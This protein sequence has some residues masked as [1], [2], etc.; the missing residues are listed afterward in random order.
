[1]AVDPV[2]LLV[3][4]VLGAGGAALL[5]RQ[6]EHARVPDGLAD[7]LGWGFLVDEGV[8]ALKDGGLLAAFRYRGPDLGS[9]TG[10]ELAALTEQL[11]D[12]LLP[13]GD[14]WMFHVDAIREP[15]PPYAASRFPD[16]VTAWIDAERRQAYDVVSGVGDRGHATPDERSR[17]ADRRAG[18]LRPGI[19]RTGERRT[20]AARPQFVSTYTLTATF[21][22]PKELYTRAG[23]LFVQPGDRPP[24]GGIEHAGSAIAPG[25]PASAAGA[26][27]SGAWE[28]MLAGYT[29]ALRTLEDRIGAR[30]HVERL[31]SDAL[32]THLHRTLTGLAH[33]VEA[34]PAGA[35]LD[36]VLASQ[37]L[38][39]GFAPRVGDQHLR[40][41]AITGYPATATAGRLDVLN[42]LPFAYRWSSRF[43]PLSQHAA[44]KLLKRHQQQWFMGRKGLGSFLRDIASTSAP[45]DWQ[46]QQ[47]ETLFVDQHASA[48]ARD[49]ADAMAENAS[50]AV[51]F[52]L[53]SQVVVTWD[54]DPDVAEA[55]ARAV[56]RTL[57]DAGVTARVETVNALD[58]FLGTLPGHGYANLRRQV[59]STPNAAALWPVTS[60]W[61]GQGEHPS[62]F[63]P[64]ASP[65]LM[66]VATDGSTPFRLNLHVSDLGHTL[67][68]G[69]PGAGKSTFVGLTIAQWQRY[70]ASAG[71]RTFVFDVGYSHWLLAK[72][73]GGAH[74]DIAAPGTTTPGAEDN[75]GGGPPLAF[76]PLADVE[77][78]EER[79]WAASW[80]EM[81][82]E[83]QGVAMTPT[84]RLALDRALV[85]L[86][87]QPRPYRTLTELAVQCQDPDVVAAL[88]PY[89]VGGAWGALLDAHE[90]ALDRA[91]EAGQGGV[92]RYQV[93]E[94]RSLLD[95]DEKVLVPVLLY[96][97]RRVERQ[98]DGRPALIV[99][100]ELWAPLM[101]TAFANRIRQWLLTLRKQN[102]A[103]L[104]VAHTL[105]QLD[106]VPAKQVLIESCPTR[107]LLPN[108][109]AGSAVNR[110][111]YAELGLNDREIAI[112]A[113]AVPKRD[114]YVASPLGR[115]LVR[116]DLGPVALAFLGTPPGLTLDRLR[117]AVETLAA[118][119]GRRWPA[120]WLAQWGIAVPDV[121]GPEA[122]E[123]DSRAWEAPAWDTPSRHDRA[124]APEAPSR[125]EIPPERAPVVDLPV[126]RPRVH[127]ADRT[128]AFHPVSPAASAPWRAVPDLPPADA[129]DAHA[130]A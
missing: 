48:M 94:L 104:L 34:P 124:R 46:R 18:A 82:C 44:E 61:A 90:D 96:L 56:C 92:P 130:P 95:L 35:Y 54:R 53:S 23:R 122:P 11:N 27:S 67:L 111:L 102:A 127:D 6:R 47:E 12:A 116:L 1:M 126:G 28:A 7:L 79:A 72:A 107:V 21:L 50:G 114:Y 15:A 16:P 128:P 68:V 65:P 108:P 100:E 8:V 115:R 105:A 80:L 25:D 93:F 24:Q 63:F 22:P 31:G 36:Q 123:R 88:Q 106:A 62:P 32:V 43:V 97:F 91:D 103:V 2:S 73:A 52:G 58:A 87:G 118:R 66:T 30:L 83:L 42:T 109:E 119:E 99:I 33:P 10:P 5:A 74:Y 86:A 51:R 40:V 113:Q 37:E 60:V 81:L 70:A 89:T 85:L 3:G 41:V 29:E 38:V 39:G 26:A 101:R 84:R 69:A 129:E 19:P 121:L 76:Q 20:A 71:A 9:A 112:I 59:V 64:P 98:L 77:R 117:P 125:H 120:A 75:A 78:S 57:Q 45:S 49:V 17:G 4:G 13:F 110:R 14:G 55:H